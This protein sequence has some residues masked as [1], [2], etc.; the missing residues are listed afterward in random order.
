[1]SSGHTQSADLSE[2]PLMFETDGLRCLC[3]QVSDDAATK[4]G[5]GLIAAERQRQIDQEGWSAEHDAQHAK[6]DLAIAAACYALDGI[7]P[8]ERLAFF[9][10]VPVIWPWHP[11]LW[12]PTDR[13][14]DLVKAGALIAAEIDRLEQEATH[15]D[16]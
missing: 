6:G 7:S 1:M 12:K 9:P 15:E 10:R 13:I 8:L 11:D 4:T 16:R 5:A 3:W 2:A 14:M